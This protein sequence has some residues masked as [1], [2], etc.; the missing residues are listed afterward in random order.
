MNKNYFIKN[1]KNILFLLFLFLNLFFSR[2]SYSETIYLIGS[3][4]TSSYSIDNKD[5]TEINNKLIALGFSD[6]S[7]SV[8]TE[9]LSYKLG[10]GI[11]LPLLFSIESSYA[12]L[13]EIKFTS[14]TTPAET[15][16]AD[17]KIRGVSLDILKGLGPFSLSAGFMRLDDTIKI[18]SSRGSVDVPVDKMLIPKVGANIKL[19]NYRLEYS[20]IFI[21]PNSEINSLMISYIFNLL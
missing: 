1:C 15:I 11:K 19:S 4:G 5:K 10:L 2:L 14:E 6:A 9:D 12:N 21:T 20:R 17:A 13:G 7:T 16:T 18:S 8:K 3:L